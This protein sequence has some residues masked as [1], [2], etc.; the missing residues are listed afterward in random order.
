MQEVQEF[1]ESIQYFSKK[2]HVNYDK[3]IYYTFCSCVVIRQRWKRKKNYN[4]VLFQVF[5]REWK[6]FSS[7][8]LNYYGTKITLNFHL[9]SH[10]KFNL[11]Q[12]TVINLNFDLILKINGSS[13]LK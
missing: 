1:I 11:A 12:K 2:T 10:K 6:F 8:I 4:I 5:A 3:L 13:R 9:K 7:K